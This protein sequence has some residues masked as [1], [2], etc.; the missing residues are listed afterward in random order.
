MSEEM[1]KYEIRTNR[2]KRA[3]IEAARELFGLNGY[4]KTGIKDIAAKAGVSQVSIYNYFGSKEL[5]VVECAKAIV[6]ETIRQANELLLTDKPFQEKLR[7]ALSLCSGEINGAIE[8]YF[9]TIP[10]ADDNFKR[11]LT[12]GV[13]E[14]QREMHIRYIRAGKE[15]GCIDTSLPESAILKYIEAI[16]HIY[17][18]SDQYHEELTA[19]HQLFLHGVLK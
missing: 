17:I 2:K 13:F 8:E 7:E 9:S 10:G 11:L 15:A 18:S 12:A 16:N 3:I 6:H 19:I 1:N 4:T 14:A 5:L